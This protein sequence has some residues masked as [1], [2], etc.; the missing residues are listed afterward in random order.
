MPFPRYKSESERNSVNGVRTRWLRCRWTARQS[1]RPRGSPATIQPTD[2]RIKGVYTFPYGISSKINLI[3]QLLFERAYYNLA[4][5]QADNYATRT[6][7]EDIASCL[8]QREI[9]D[10]VQCHATVTLFLYMHTNSHTSVIAIDC[11]FIFSY[12]WVVGASSF[13]IQDFYCA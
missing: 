13:N 2:H 3:A 4:A 6:I 9:I 1:I 10:V 12:I 11:I 5:R 8:F 7:P